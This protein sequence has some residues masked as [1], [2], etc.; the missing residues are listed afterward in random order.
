MAEAFAFEPG[1]QTVDLS[2]LVKKTAEASFLA[3]KELCDS[4]P[5]RSDTEKKIGLLKFIN[6]TRQRLLRLLVL[7]KWCNQITLVEYCQQL[8]GTLSNH[9]TSFVQAADSLF[10]LHEGLQQA[11]APMYD[12]PSA[13]EVLLTGS[14]RRLPKCIEDLGMQPM[15]AGEE[16]ES[17]LQKL[18]TMLRSRLLDIPLPKEITSVKVAKG[19]ITLHVEEE[20]EAQ[21]TLGYRG[22][23]L[24]WRVL[25]LKILVGEHSGT[26]KL[27]GL[28]EGGL[29]DDLERRMAALDDPFQILYSVLHEFC[30]AWVMDT[31]IRQVRALQQGRWKDAIR[32]DLIQDNLAGN[33]VQNAGQ[34][35]GMDIDGEAD[36]GNVKAHL[37]PGLKI[38]Y[39]LDLSKGADASSLPSLRIEQGPDHHLSCSHV[40][41]VI[42]SATDYDAQFQINLASIDVERLLLR[43]ILCNVHTRL[44][45]VHRLLRSS[46]QLCRVESDVILHTTKTTAGIGEAFMTQDGMPVG[47]GEVGEEVLCVRAYGQSYMAL[48]I[49]IRSGK[50]ILRSHST[51]IAP[52]LLAE[53]EDSLNQGLLSPLDAFISLR[54][55]SLL[56]LYADIGT[57]LKLKILEKGILRLKLPAEGPKI[58]TET[59]IMAFPDCG[60]SFFL[61]LQLDSEFMPILT[62]IE[63]QPQQG[64][65]LSGPV[66]FVRYMSIDVGSFFVNEDEVNFSLLNESRSILQ[67][68]DGLMGGLIEGALTSGHLDSPGVKRLGAGFDSGFA[69]R[70]EKDRFFGTQKGTLLAAQTWRQNDLIAGQNQVGIVN[71]SFLNKTSP[72]SNLA[73]KSFSGS[74]SNAGM[75]SGVRQAVPGIGS[76]GGTAS[77]SR[78]SPGGITS[79]SRNLPYQRANI[80]PRPMPETDGLLLKSPLNPGESSTS[81]INLDDDDLSKLID[82]IASKPPAPSTINVSSTFDDGV[83]L[84]SPSRQTRTPTALRGSP[85]YRNSA[86]NA[87]SSPKNSLSQSNLLRS[88]VSSPG[89]SGQTPSP[90]RRSPMPDAAGPKTDYVGTIMDTSE[91]NEIPQASLALSSPMKITTP[92]ISESS[93]QNK[94]KRKNPDWLLTLPCLQGVSRTIVSKKRKIGAEGFA[95]PVESFAFTTSDMSGPSNASQLPVGNQYSVLIAAANEGK[96]LLSSYT[97]FLLQVTRRCCLCIKKARLSSQMNALNIP[98]LEEVGLRKPST[99][100]W[101]RLH[102]FKNGVGSRSRDLGGWENICLCVGN[103]GSAVWSVKIHD[104]YMK[105]LYELQKQKISPQSATAAQVIASEADSHI[106]CNSDG[107]FL[108]YNSVEDD[109]IKNM[110]VDLDRLWN[111]RAFAL[112]MKR[113][114][115]NKADEKGELVQDRSSKSQHKG[116]LGVGEGEKSWEVMRRAFRVEAIGLTSVWFNYTGAFIARFVVEWEKGKMGCTMHVSPDQLWPHTKYLEDYI[117]GG[118]VDLLLDCIRVTAGPLHALAGAIRP[119]RMPVATTP[120]TSPANMGPGGSGRANQTIGQVLSP[121]TPQVTSPSNN[122]GRVSSTGLSGGSTPVSANSVQGSQNGAIVSGPGR[123]TGLVP[124]SLLPTDVSVVLRSPYWIRIVYRRQFAVDMR[125]FAGDQVWLQPAPPPRG[126]GPGS[127]GSLPCPQFRPFVMEQITYNNDSTPMSGAGQPMQ[128]GPL[129]IANGS[130]QSLAQGLS[131]RF[132]ASAVNIARPG[133]GNGSQP[134]TILRVGTP[135]NLLSSQ[136]LVSLSSMAPGRSIVP[137]VSMGFH[138]SH[139]ELNAAGYG[140]SDDGGYGGV[141]V[142]LAFLKKVLRGTLRYLGVVWLFAQFPEI[143]KEVLAV[144]LKENE[145]AL[146]NHDPETPALRFYVQNCVFAVSVHRQQLVLQAINVKRFQ[147]QPQPQQPQSQQSQPPPQQ[148]QQQPQQSQSQPQQTQVLQ[149]PTAGSDSDLSPAEMQEIGDFFARRAAFEPYDA[150]RL[151]SFVTMLT[152]PVP[153]LREFIGLIAWKKDAAKAA[154]H[155][156]A[157]DINQIPRPKLELCLENRSGASHG[158]TQE[159]S[160]SSH[161]LGTGASSPKSSIDYDRS[162]KIVD[163]TLTVI[164]DPIHVPHINVAGGAGWLPQCVAIRLRYMFG[165]GSNISLLHMEGSHGGRACWSRV[166]DWERCKERI[167]RALEVPGSGNAA[168]QGQGRLRAVGETIQTTLQS[169]LQQLRKGSAN[170]LSPTGGSL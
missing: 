47:D 98:Y 132:N 143:I 120:I 55:K 113:L 53:A 135:G 73:G 88:S 136:G 36:I 22:Y 62:L 46:S 79:P 29:K 5:E 39:W 161:S 159:D 90:A 84:M 102:I 130:V 68:R 30:S 18:D 145:G 2:A 64:S 69:H 105:E 106:R 83:S 17:T 110:M 121:T 4:S 117:N 96:A 148:Q 164:F 1:Q 168:D 133:S 66:R 57:S 8:V 65:M 112:E 42:D 82:S 74:S 14:Y 149:Q 104:H 33:P 54:N 152:L 151:A 97:G 95:Q 45:E 123:G 70:L 60:L 50:F 38:I 24:L 127:K 34:G 21:L 134:P 63:G 20:F 155:M 94:Q 77:P 122:H 27:T 138:P 119:A 137:G 13:V 61:M 140:F 169:A 48:G 91:T 116:L 81:P 109:S 43:A 28:Q 125:C 51:S 107:L 142:P 52:A 85:L 111:A 6:R 131:S 11:R 75:L 160:S 16:K 162:R 35:L 59:L 31:V 163:F 23:P 154:Q 26:L 103:P 41:P 10:F 158:S 12:I 86:Q 19:M 141:W 150:S 124:S 101:F 146:L 87:R 167:A 15:L 129:G 165:D 144:H 49:N 139:R 114:L 72:H 67:S 92:V 93:M 100:L 9:D 128:G 37:S 56:Q 32:F 7:S 147:H 166:E 157:N 44:L 3:F 25:H 170:V 58:G 108:V 99:N 153:V 78:Y 156:Q 80:G 115:E 71:Q 126:I 89:G 76:P 40:P 118:E